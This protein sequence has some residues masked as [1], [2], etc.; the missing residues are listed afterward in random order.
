MQPAR[1]VFTASLPV[2][3]R[4]IS[5]GRLGNLKAGFLAAIAAFLLMIPWVD[6]VGLEFGQV[7]VDGISVSAAVVMTLAVLSAMAS[8]SVLSWVSKSIRPAGALLS[9]ITGTVLIIPFIQVIGPMTS[10]LVG[11]VAG[12]SAVMLQKKMPDPARNRHVV[13]AAVTLA[14]THLALMLLILSAQ[15]SHIWDTGGGI[16][17]WNGTAEVIEERGFV[18]KDEIGFAHLAVTVPSLATAVWIIRSKNED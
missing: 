3:R 12:F 9:V 16:G 15:S 17:S 14:A 18:I 7:Q 2:R 1:A 10:V 6:K 11:A 5:S 13:I 8:W 4:T